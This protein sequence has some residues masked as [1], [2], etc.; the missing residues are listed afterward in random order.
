MG[1][2]FAYIVLVLVTAEAPKQR[3][4]APILIGW[5]QPMGTEARI[6]A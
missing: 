6:Q 1:K 5:F 2:D 4:V 3:N